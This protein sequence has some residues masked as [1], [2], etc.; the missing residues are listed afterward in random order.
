MQF[1]SKIPIWF[2]RYLYRRNPLLSRLRV[3]RIDLAGTADHETTDHV[4]EFIAGQQIEEGLMFLEQIE[5]G[6]IFPVQR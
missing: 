4:E 1:N 2:T 6:L 5:E 3:I